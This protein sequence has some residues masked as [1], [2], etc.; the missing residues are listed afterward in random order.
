VPPFFINV[1]QGKPT[2]KEPR[3]MKTVGKKPRQQP[4]QYWGCGRDHMYRY[5]PQRGEKLRT[6]HSIQ[7]V[8]TVEYMGI[9]VPRIYAAL[10]NKQD[11][12]QS[13]MIEVE[14]KIN[15]QTISILIDSRYSHS[16]LDPNMVERF[17]LPRSKLGKP[18]LV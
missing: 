17:Q 2:P 8:A 11:K 4:I 14:S 16:Y 15:D 12:F 9:N 10:D 5:F 18:W 1:M 3:M 13:H 7:Q 6:V